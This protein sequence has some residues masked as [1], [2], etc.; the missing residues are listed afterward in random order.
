MIP[1]DGQLAEQYALPFAEAAYTSTHAPA[2]YE[3]GR[4]CFE[5]VVDQSH[6]DFQKQLA[7][8]T[9]KHRKTL[10][11]MLDQQDEPQ[12]REHASRKGLAAT[13]RN[14]KPNKHLGWVCVDATNQRL[15]VAF[16]G[17]EFFSDWLDDFDFSP[18]PYDPVPGSGNVHQGFQL[19]YYA[20]RS[21]LRA[22]VRAQAPKC[23]QLF[24][25][26]HSLG[27]ALCGLAAPDLL[28]D[29]P[30]LS[31]IVYSWAEPRVGH[32]D[33]RSFFDKHV[34]ICYRITNLCDIVPHLPPALF[35]YWHEGRHVGINS[36]LSL[37]TVRSHIL[38]TGYLPGIRRWN[39]HHPAN[40]KAA[41]V[42]G[43]G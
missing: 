4:N 18:S 27:G 20:I 21:G 37:D 34:G 17:T 11:S 36:G 32:H 12:L 38:A 30:A 6:P 35:A 7:K 8:S 29:A 1:F 16:R 41:V 40:G 24:I 22:T 13:P 31:P 28:N 10:Q 14:A 15:V 42:A 2:G 25:T 39:Q 3:A 5:I 23:R 9:Q 33:Y 43:S 19:V 26:G